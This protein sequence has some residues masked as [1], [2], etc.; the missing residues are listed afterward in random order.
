MAIQSSQFEQE[1]DKEDAM[2]TFQE[3]VRAI[4][5]W[6]SHQLR[7]LNQDAART[8]CIDC[9]SDNSVLLIQDWAMKFLPRQYRESQGEWFA[10]KGFSWHI[11][12][13]IRKTES[14]ME[15]QAFVHV[16][17]QCNQD[18]PCV[19]MLMEHVLATLKKENPD[20]NRAFYRQD[21]AGCYHAAYTILAC[22]EISKRTGVCVQRLDFSDP[23]GGKGPCDRFAATMKNHVHAFID[24]GNDVSTTAQFEKALTSHGGVPGAR[25]SLI[26]GSFT[27]KLT[28][29]LPGISKLNNFEFEN[30]GVRVWRAYGVGEGKLF[31]WSNFKGA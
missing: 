23:Q 6:K 19:V 7:L 8:D 20:I 4:Q 5:L 30:E 1:Y 24:E 13:A 12:V 25:V 18:S 26:Q 31:P 17:E 3:A 9:L 28:V 29:K 16:V 2:Y 22:K 21:N 11:T 14:G 10:K 15:T 27:D